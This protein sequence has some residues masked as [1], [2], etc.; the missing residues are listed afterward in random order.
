M[1]Y[2]VYVAM[3]REELEALVDGEVSFEMRERFMGHL[4]GIRQHEESME[5]SQEVG[6]RHRWNA[7][8]KRLWEGS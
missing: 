3:N 6:E 1:N 8:M 7:E 5:R 2:W 4:D